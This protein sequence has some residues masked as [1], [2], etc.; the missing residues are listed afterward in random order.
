MQNFDN[1]HFAFKGTVGQVH[2]LTQDKG[3]NPVNLVH[4]GVTLTYFDDQLEKSKK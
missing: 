2:F 4:K 1:N 3:N